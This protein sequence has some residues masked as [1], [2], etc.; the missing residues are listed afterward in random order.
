[1]ADLSSLRCLSLSGLPSRSAFSSSSMPS[2]INFTASLASRFSPSA[3]IA[4]APF[5]RTSFA[6][7]RSSAMSS[8]LLFASARSRGL[9]ARYASYALARSSHRRALNHV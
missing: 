6:S 4:A 2:F 5:L 3:L 8:C 9:N 1:M 7:L